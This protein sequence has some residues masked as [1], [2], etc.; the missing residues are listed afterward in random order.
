MA[1]PSP[2][3]EG[4]DISKNFGGV[5]ALDHAAFTARP[6]EVHALVGENG[7]GK[8]TMIKI[9]SGLIHPDSGTI[10]IKG[11][12]VTLAGP[13]AAQALGVRTVFQELTLMPWMT[14]AE[15]LLLGREPRGIF[16]LIQREKMASVAEKILMD[17]GIGQIDPLDLVADLSLSQRQI[18]E[19]ARAVIR[20]PDV[21]FLDEPTSSLAEQG[22]KWLFQLIEQLRA[23]NKCIIFTSHRWREVKSIASRITIFRNGQNVGTYTD[24]DEDQAITLMTG[25]NVEALYPKLPPLTEKETVLE[26]K[27]MSSTGVHDVSFS[28]RKGEILGI[29]GLA[30]HGHR[31]LFLTLFGVQK[32]THGQMLIGGKPVNIRGPRDAIA[33]GLGI[34]LVPEDR[35]S[36]GLLLP[37]S[38]QDNL[39]LPILDRISPWGVVKR[40]TERQLVQKMI[41]RLQIKTPSASR[42]VGTLSGGNQQKVL[43]G[44]WLLADSRILLLYDVTRGV[45]IATKHDVYELMVQLAA[46]GRS[47]LFYSSDTEEIAHLC[48]RVLVMREGRISVELAGPEISAEEIVGAAVRERA[49]V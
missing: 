6:G 31:E 39:T 41:E 48:H 42:P 12:D 22:V 15:N 14:V 49:R 4:L 19:I 43:I 32:A 26:V 3:I 33:A 40:G 5:R 11:Q 34:A 30:G 44:R 13:G 20:D 29:G 45:D 28:L 10:R 7:A 16:G 18:I 17:L 1:E 38:V 46:E 25:R 23:R 35:K 8:S 9:L 36:E 37:M 2:A 47:V 27:D 24:I 21:L